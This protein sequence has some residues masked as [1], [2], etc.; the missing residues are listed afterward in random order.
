MKRKFDQL[1]IEDQRRAVEMARK[2]RQQRENK[3]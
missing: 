3:P 1:S 2:I